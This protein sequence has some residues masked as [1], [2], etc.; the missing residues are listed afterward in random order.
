[1]KHDFKKAEILKTAAK[2]F[3]TKGYHATRIQDIADALGMHKGSLYYY[4]E[5]KEDLLKG[6]VEDI[7]EQSVE[8][9]SNIHNTQHRPHEKVRLCI[10][11]HLHL[12]HNNLDAFGVFINEDLELINKTSDKDVFGLMK[13]YEHGWMELFTEGIKTGEFDK[14]KNYKIIV[15][16]IFGMLNWSYRWYHVKS[17]YTMKEVSE[18]F[19]DLILNGIGEPVNANVIM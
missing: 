9:L 14:N 6:L 8:L 1:M 16:G 11:S 17:G 3:R 4:I 10:E 12:F 5:T 15:K 2:V 13:E 18:V 7:L 19:S